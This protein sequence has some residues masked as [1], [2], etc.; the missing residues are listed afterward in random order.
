MD[1]DCVSDDNQNSQF[2]DSKFHFRACK[3]LKRNKKSI[4]GIQRYLNSC[5]C[6]FIWGHS[7]ETVGRSRTGSTERPDRDR[8]GPGKIGILESIV[9]LYVRSS[10]SRQIGPYQMVH[11]I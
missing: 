4:Y 9:E 10:E 7:Q 11:I 2:P 8:T 1:S 3:G 6:Y 5:D